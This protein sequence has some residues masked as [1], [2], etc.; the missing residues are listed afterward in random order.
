MK[1]AILDANGGRQVDAVLQMSGGAAFEGQLRALAPFGRMVTFGIASREENQVRTGHLLRNSRSV[2]GF[3][4]VHL[5]AHP[6]TVAQGIGELFAAVEAEEL[7]VVISG[8]HPLSEARAVHEALAARTT[9][10]KMLLDPAS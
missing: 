5:L 1:D 8:V 7:E 10:G 6:A 3:W 2:I 4:L 9:Q